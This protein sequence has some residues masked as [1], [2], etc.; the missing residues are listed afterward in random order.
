MPRKKYEANILAKLKKYNTTYETS[1]WDDKN[2]II[3]SNSF[4]MELWYSDPIYIF[5]YKKKHNPIF[6]K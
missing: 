6:N 2:M 1:N 4:E 5:F 3:K